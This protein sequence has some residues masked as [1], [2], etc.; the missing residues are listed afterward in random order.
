MAVNVRP[1]LLDYSRDRIPAELRT[2]NTESI[3]EIP[4]FS[5]MIAVSGNAR[6]YCATYDFGEVELRV[7]RI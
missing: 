2:P 1:E 6:G 3:S 4:V 7:P 5:W